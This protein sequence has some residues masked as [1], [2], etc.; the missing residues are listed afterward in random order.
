MKSRIETGEIKEGMLVP[1]KL[2]WGSKSVM[3]VDNS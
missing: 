3:L 2:E 1:E